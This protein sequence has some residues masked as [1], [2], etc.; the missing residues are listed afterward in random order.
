[1]QPCSALDQEPRRQLVY[2]VASRLCKMGAY[3]Y[4][5]LKCPQRQH[6]VTHEHLCDFTTAPD[7]GE[8]CLVAM[9]CL[10]VESDA[11]PASAAVSS[12]M[13]I[14]KEQGRP[15]RGRPAATPSVG[16]L[17]HRLLYRSCHP[18][19]YG[20]AAKYILDYVTSMYAV[21]YSTARSWRR[22]L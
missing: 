4:M 7:T 22:L 8:P 10:L 15:H 11:R 13:T 16:L 5:Y 21:M 20:R 12:A 6:R 1:L 3:M 18:P 14:V 19:I 9:V 2:H 17:A